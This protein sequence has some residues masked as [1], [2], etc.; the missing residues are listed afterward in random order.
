MAILLSAYSNYCNTVCGVLI[1][2]SADAAGGESELARLLACLLAAS[3]SQV[4]IIIHPS[5]RR[6]T[7][8]ILHRNTTPVI[9]PPHTTTTIELRAHISSPPR[10][11]APSL[12]HYPHS[13]IGSKRQR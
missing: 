8:N 13:D 3:T 9:Q 1:E 6:A 10:L 12:L 5:H 2:F 7:K 4:D 11:R